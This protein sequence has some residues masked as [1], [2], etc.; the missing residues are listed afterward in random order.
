MFLLNIAG[1][2]HMTDV[3]VHIRRIN[4]ANAGDVDLR[5]SQTKTTATP[6]D[7]TSDNGGDGD[8]YVGTIFDDS[9][10]IDVEAYA[11]PFTA[12][13][14][15][16]EPLSVFINVPVAG[17]WTLRVD[18]DNG[19]GGGSPRDT[20]LVTWG[21]TVKSAGCVDPDGDVIYS[22][23][24]NCPDNGNVGQQ[25]RDQDGP[26]D[27]CDTDD[28]ADGTPDANDACSLGV[29]GVGDDLDGDG[30]KAGEDGDD[31]GD[32]KPDA[33]DPCAA[34]ATGA[35]DD[36]DGDGCKSGEDSDDDGDGKPDA[37][38]ACAAGE[39]GPGA[40]GDGDG[41]KDSEDADDDNDGKTDAN[42]RCPTGAVGTAP[43]RDGDGCSDGEDTDNDDDGVLDATDACRL[44]SG[45]GP[46][47]CPVLPRAVT[48][49]YSPRTRKFAGRVTGQNLGPCAIGQLVRLR[50]V[51]KGP[52]P[53]V[54]KT[55]RTSSKGRFSVRRRVGKGRY[56][57]EVSAATVR[58]VVLCAAT[59]SK[60]VSVR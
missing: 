12:R 29:T 11:A 43:D 25:D 57:A 39:V 28:D 30:C 5:L 16:E 54:G 32:G 23:I 58:D 53:Q 41:C 7:L 14:R 50:Q 56:Y 1:S 35:G 2:G 17:L 9:A 45:P 36:L 26:G 4:A 6:I 49:T 60:S 13:L 31:D 47:G 27:A 8:N 18:D 42:D 46:V 44:L 55:L 20:T 51:R 38:D 24:D 34:G 37:D 52:D 33:E 48:L 21:I 15:P 3:D 59:K 40:D 10:S 22:T 19:P